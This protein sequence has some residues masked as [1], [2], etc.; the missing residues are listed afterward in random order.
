MEATRY[1]L[2]FITGV[3]LTAATYGSGT[4]GSGTYGEQASD[5]VSALRYLLVPFPGGVLSDPSWVYR[6]GDTKP[7]LR[8]AIVADDGFLD[9]SG[10]DFAHL[11]LTNTDGATD[12]TPL[13]YELTVTAIDGQNWLTRN[14]LPEDL[15]VAGTFRAAAVL[16]YLSGR[17]L[18]VPAHDGHQF[19]VTP[20]S[21]LEL[22][23]VPPARWDQARWSYAHW[24]EAPS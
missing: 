1:R 14:W 24:S 18:T 7:S 20:N 13:M 10:L 23:A 8:A 2:R 19:T 17:R 9:F 4:Y 6:Q 11:V 16:Q 3:E 15:V 22:P 5:A 12:M 21:A